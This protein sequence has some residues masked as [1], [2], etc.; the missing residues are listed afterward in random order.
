MTETDGAVTNLIERYLAIVANDD[1]ERFGE[2][3]TD[4]PAL[5]VSRATVYP[6]LADHTEDA[7]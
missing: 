6:V 3:L 1:Y 4:D 7:E 5:A 2:L